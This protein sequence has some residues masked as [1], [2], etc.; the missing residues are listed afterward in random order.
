MSFAKAYFDVKSAVF[1]AVLIGA[2]GITLAGCDTLSSINPFDRSET[3]K[4]EI[5]ADVPGEQLYNDG[6]A[7][8]QNKD[9]ERAAKKFG[10]LEKQHPQSEWSRKALIMTAYA[11][12]EGGLYDDAAVAAKRY[13]TQY[14]ATSDAA[15]AQYILAMSYYNQIPDI[16]RDQETSERALG[17]LQDLVERYPTSEYAKDAKEKIQVARDQLAGKE[18]EIGRF[19]LQKRN[20]PGAINRF[21]VVVSRYQTTRHVE[22]ALERLAE[23]YM[24]MGIVGEA[25]TAA[26]V[27][28]HNFPDSQWYKDA[29]SLLAKGGVEPREDSESWISKAFRGVPQVGQRAG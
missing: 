8:I 29:Y 15:Y 23:A 1:R 26:A 2:C 16:T 4:P 12:Y 20:Y 18:V 27:L 19:Y 3:Y 22:E 7:R 9:Y 11:N 14:P 13:L 25:Q 10:D 17:T 6:L 24:S 28:G 21:R 5:V